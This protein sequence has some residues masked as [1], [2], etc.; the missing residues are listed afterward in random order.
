VRNNTVLAVMTSHLHISFRIYDNVFETSF[1][2]RL[3]IGLGA[4]ETRVLKVRVLLID[5]DEGLTACHVKC[6]PDATSEG[7]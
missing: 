6:K 2:Q 3:Y 1:A 5:V 4:N 7:P